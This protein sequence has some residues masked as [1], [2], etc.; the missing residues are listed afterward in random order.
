M[1]RL[2]QRL[3]ITPNIEPSNNDF[4]PSEKVILFWPNIF[5]IG[6]RF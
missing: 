3:G 6:Y 1:L 4:Y 2:Q 5:T